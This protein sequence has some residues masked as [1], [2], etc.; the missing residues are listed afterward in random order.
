MQFSTISCGEY[1]QKSPSF[2]GGIQGEGMPPKT[3]ILSNSLLCGPA[4][5][6]LLLGELSG[7]FINGI[8]P[9]SSD[10]TGHLAPA[11]KMILPLWSQLEALGTTAAHQLRI[12][13]TTHGACSR[14]LTMTKDIGEWLYKICES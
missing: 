6:I 7:A 8:E 2:S 12:Y 4:A 14:R 5:G 13:P 11:D 9:T 1:A 3:A 10:T